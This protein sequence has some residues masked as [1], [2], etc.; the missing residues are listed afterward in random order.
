MEAAQNTMLSGC[1]EAFFGLANLEHPCSGS[2]DLSFLIFW[3]DSATKQQSLSMWACSRLWHQAEME[4]ALFLM[5]EGVSNG[6][7]NPKPFQLILVS[8][9]PYRPRGVE[10]GA[11]PLHR[12][13]AC[14]HCCLVFCA[15]VAM[16]LQNRMYVSLLRIKNFSFERG[17][18]FIES[19]ASEC[20]V[21]GSEYQ[22]AQPVG[23]SLSFAPLLQ[24]ML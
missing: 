5:S 21:H 1:G 7:L 20:F 2:L 11:W 23:S 18:G 10:C 19:E 16:L 9:A 3:H 17:F 15:D 4:G 12:T 14:P 22:L 8:I 13:A 24:R 6:S